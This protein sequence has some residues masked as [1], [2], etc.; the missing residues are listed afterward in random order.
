MNIKQFFMIDNNV[1]SYLFLLLISLFMLGANPFKAETIAPMDLLVKYPGWKNTNIQLDYI[2]GER[3]DALDAKLPIWISA[4]SELYKGNIPIWNYQRGGKPGLTFTNSL[5]TPAFVAFA[6]VKDHALGF[7]LSNLI[8]LL[9]G[10]LGMY[11]FL[12]LFLGQTASVFGAFIFMFSGFNAAWFFWAHVDT[13]IWTPWVLFTVYKYIDTLEKKYLPFV[14]LT[15]LMLNLGGFPMVAVMTYMSIAI[16]VLIFLISKRA[17]IKQWLITTLNLALFSLLAVIIALPF[18]YPLVELLEWMGGIGY[19]SGGAGFKLN[20]LQ[21][22]INPNFYRIPKV[23]TTFYVGILPVLFLFVALILY[24][25]KP[26]FIAFFGFILFV[27]STTIAFTLISPEIIHKIPTLNSSLLTRFGFLIGLSLAIIAA[28][29]LQVMIEK[30]NHSK[31]V[32]LMIPM[33]FSIQIIDQKRLFNSFNAA[34]PNASFYPQTKSISYLQKNVKPFQYLIADGGFLIAGTLGGYR[35]NDWYAHS[36]HSAE[37]KTILNELVNKPFKTPTSATFAFSQINLDSPYL[38]YLAIRY[39]LS[40]SLSIEDHIPLWDNERAQLPSPLLSTSVFIQNFHMKEDKE[41]YG[42]SLQMATYGAK[43][44]SSDVELIL[45]SEGKEIV[46]SVVSKEMIMDNKWVPF[47]FGKTM[48]LNAGDYSVSIRMLSDLNIKPLAIW[49]N[50]GETQY[51]LVA[52]GEEQNLSLKMGWSKKRI[53][54][55]KFKIL[56]LEPD[57]HVIEN[58]HIQGGAYFL[59]SLDKTHTVDYSNTTTTLLSNTEIKIQYS[60]NEDGWVILPMRSYPGWKATVNEKEIE[61]HKFL[62]ML[63]A[64]KVNGKSTVYINYAPAYNKYTYAF[65]V[66]SLFI[67]LFSILKFRR[68]D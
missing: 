16:M 15:M 11:L 47:E 46:S 29:V 4:K 44:A 27:Y 28:Y 49:T 62:G 53:F 23:E 18:I 36:F 21:L 20:A 42:L 10:L 54:D 33:I 12:R 55:E 37:E 65:A 38:D 48:H 52:N 26:R 2:N 7:Y 25:L 5:L 40:T 1:K 64:I 30:F 3:S 19:R 56:N 50:I 34:V 35:L 22:F 66:L 61:I 51:K 8:N 43:H 57:I 41:V 32:Y 31:W 63:P 17:S 60:G 24:V 58:L 6:I 9:I 67:L 13:T 59:K 68:N 45:S 14:A 39:M